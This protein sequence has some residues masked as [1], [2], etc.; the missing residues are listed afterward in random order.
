MYA[1]SEAYIL[2]L[3]LSSLLLLLR[4]RHSLTHS[5]YV[6]TLPL[7]PILVGN[8]AIKSALS[9]MP[10]SSGIVHP[11]SFVSDSPQ[12]STPSI[13]IP[14][15]A[16]VPLTSY[17]T[18]TRCSHLVGAYI[19]PMMPSYLQL[20]QPPPKDLRSVKTNWVNKRCRLC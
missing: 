14:H 19:V 1:T 15:D 12:A 5:I 3:L 6:L 10:S 20:Q 7:R 16:I 11:T 8:V 17:N 4:A 13:P 18:N 9:S 2:L